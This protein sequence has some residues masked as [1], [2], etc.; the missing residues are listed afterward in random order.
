M[1]YRILILE[2]NRIDADLVQRYL[3]RSEDNYEIKWVA[4]KDEYTNML[5][6]FKP[7]LIISDYNLRYYNA[8]DALEIKNE[9][10]KHLPLIVLS[11]TIGEEEA[12]NLIKEGAI[13]F[14]IKYNLIRLPQIVKRALEETSE[15]KER[16]KAERALRKE[17]FFTDK[18]LNSLSGIFYL[19]DSDNNVSRVNNRFLS[20]LGYRWE[21]VEGKPFKNFISE[22]DYPLLND[23]V[24]NLQKQDEA[25]VELRLKDKN[26]TPNHFLLTGAN[27]EQEGKQY[28]IGTA[29]EITDRIKAEQQIKEAL[30]EKNVLL[31]EIHHRVKNN[32]A[33]VSGMMQL[34]AFEEEGDQ[35]VQEKLL[36]SVSRIKSIAL[37]HEQMYQSESFSN[38]RFDESLKLLVENISHISQM[39][40]KVKIKF[41]TQKIELNIN[42]ALPCAIIINEVVTN[43]FKHAFKGRKN[44]EIKIQ[45]IE[46]NGRVELSIKDNGRG[47]PEN[48]T[49]DKSP[50]LGL[51]LINLLSKQLN[52][53]VEL[54]SKSGSNFSLQFK[55]L[56]KKGVGSAN[57]A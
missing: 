32:L 44:G 8:Y 41:D 9:Y 57:V 20:L 56:A 35:Y 6:E 33:V 2:D 7:D 39:E 43:I 23:A 26:G 52:G 36:S 19:L 31:A 21:D 3:K 4:K 16:E 28:I 42:Q 55:K 45:A 24:K 15:K 46:K 40:T 37:V 51:K 47:V 1:S 22:E 27:L 30:Q 38:L 18:L 29:I 13:D 10:N 53:T 48:L 12:V 54:K 17:M 49:I 34:Q 14:L 25:S 5:R 11:G 50:S